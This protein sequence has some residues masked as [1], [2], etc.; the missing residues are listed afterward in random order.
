MIT[1]EKPDVV[2]NCAAV[3]NVDFC[4]EN[5]GVAMEANSVAV[6]NLAKICKDINA[7]FVTISTDYVFDG[8]KKEGY[9]E[10]DATNPLM[11]YGKS[12]LAGEL[13]ALL[14]NKSS[15]V[16]RTQSLYGLAGPKEKGYN[17]V[18]LMLKLS[19]ERDEIK[20]DQYKMAPTWTYPLAKN[21]YELIKT[22]NYGL[23]HISC[24]NATTWYEAAK[25]IMELTGSKVKITPVSN[26]FF[27]KKFKRP[28]NSYLINKRLKE[29]N[30]D[31]MP[32]WD[33]ALEEYLKL[34][35]AIK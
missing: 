32:D 5:P 19:Q 29:I 26:D 3:H 25:K 7:K 35:G 24:N 12:K 14:S 9:S 4:E 1:R 2:I 18:D 16:I 13:L 6:G 20:V 33:E 28:E 17:F 8:V 34:K 21:I 30:L 10:D 23:Y 22:E 15:F 11:E 31:L 27:Q